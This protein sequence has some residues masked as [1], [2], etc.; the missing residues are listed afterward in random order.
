[1]KRIK[2]I[3]SVMVVSTLAAC[4]TT[5]DKE[6]T[7]SDCRKAR[8][9]TI[10]GTAS[11]E[12]IRHVKMLK[13][14]VSDGSCI[15]VSINNEKISKYEKEPGKQVTVTGEVFPV[16]PTD[17]ESLAFIKVNNRRIGWGSCS[18]FYIFIK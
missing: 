6:M 12:E 15:H 8:H 2:F 16:P 14:V 9:C 18:D 13:L 7:P 1:M 11:I 3:F 4:S 10:T 17:D 5:K